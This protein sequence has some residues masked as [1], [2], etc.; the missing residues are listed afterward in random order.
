M[1]D[2]RLVELAAW[3]RARLPALVEQIIATIRT[4]I[5]LYRG[6]DL[7]PG[8]DLVRSVEH[9]LRYVTEALHDSRTP[10]DLTAPAETGRRRA[11]QGA[12]LPEVLRAYRLGFT[13]V[14][15]ALAEHVRDNPELSNT[16]LATASS[17]WRLTDDYAMALTESYRATTTELLLAQQQRRSALVEAL[18]T[19]APGAE[20]GPWEIARLLGLAPDGD[21]VVVAAETTGMVEESL[22]HIESRLAD[23]RIASAWRLT[24]ALQTGVVCLRAGQHDELLTVLRAAARA[25][26]GVSPRYQSLTET[27]RALH[28]ARVALAAIRAGRAEV[29]EFSSSPLAALVASDPDESNRAAYQVLGAVLELPEEDRAILLDTAQAWFDQA[30]STERAA[31]VLYCHPNTV[32]YRLRRI[33]ELTGRSLTEPSGI[34]DLAAALQA[35]RLRGGR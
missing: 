22:A 18:F 17:I 7:V 8:E 5:E 28:L 11:L 6:P 14:W 9:N 34:A 3:L 24:P 21:L 27:P 25:R 2:P 10:Q 16:L 29:S 20:A 23:R 19:G 15:D 31:E 33:H 12:P 1:N 13:A 30:G 26:T 35:L 32:R 4:E